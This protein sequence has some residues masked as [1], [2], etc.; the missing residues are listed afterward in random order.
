MNPIFEIY[1]NMMRD[2]DAHGNPAPGVVNL[3]SLID[4]VR[5]DTG[6]FGYVPVLTGGVL[7]K[8]SME[9][10]YAF[11]GAA[12]G[13]RRY[14]TAAHYQCQVIGRSSIEEVLKSVNDRNDASGAILS[15]TLK[16]NMS[17]NQNGKTRTIYKV[18]ITDFNAPVGILFEEAYVTHAD[19]SPSPGGFVGLMLALSDP[20]GSVFAVARWA[21]NSVSQGLGIPGDE[22]QSLMHVLLPDAAKFLNGN[23]MANLGNPNPITHAFESTRGRGLAG[24]LDGLK[25]TWWSDNIPWSTDLWGRAPM[26]AK[27]STGLKVIHDLPPGLGHGG[28]NRAPIYPVG[29]I[30]H[31]I[32][33]DVYDDD[34]LAG[35]AE[36]KT[37]RRKLTRRGE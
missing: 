20:I 27:V 31:E 7:L 28:Y 35:A 17:R 22:V 14:Y 2:P 29:K 36:F 37:A 4:E 13:V 9:R 26:I 5:S 12:Q 32:V 19:L 15:S 16:A 24:V 30:M 11:E 25:F 8:P 6:G 34:G 1:A 18:L 3:S 10:G 21:I 33:G 23:P